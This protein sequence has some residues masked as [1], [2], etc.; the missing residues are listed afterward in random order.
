MDMLPGGR[1]SPE[2][3]PR[4]GHPPQRVP[5]LRAQP[6]TPTPRL[7]L[8]GRDG[9]L[10]ILRAS[11]ADTLAGQGGLVLIG[12]E[13]GLGKSALAETLAREAV[14]VGASVLIGHC[15]D[16]TETPP[17][18]PWNEIVR[19]FRASASGAGASLVPTF[20]AAPGQPE[21]FAQVGDFL[22]SVTADTPLLLVIEDLHWADAA[23]LDLLRFVAR[24]LA[25]LPLLLLTTYRANELHRH[26]PLHTL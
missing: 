26:H 21:L 2:E 24:T 22:A 8:V 19:H 17:Y 11:L 7:P 23:S 25:S 10:G 5:A 4:S 15:Y 14:E 12:G 6:P 1:I 16:R 9:E 20:D 3:P 18:G 13:A